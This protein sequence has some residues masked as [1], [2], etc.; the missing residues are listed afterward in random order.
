ME[1]SLLIQ[2]EEILELGSGITGNGMPIALSI[3]QAGPSLS[4]IISG[5]CF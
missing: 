3:L 1:S 4:V 5:Q 2:E